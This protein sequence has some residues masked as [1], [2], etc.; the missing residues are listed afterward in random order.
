MD[1]PDPSIAA[2]VLAAGAGTRFGGP[3]GLARTAAGQPWVDRAVRTL[4]AAGCGH[5]LVAVGASAPEVTALLPPGSRAVAVPDWSDGISASVRAGLA[6]ATD[7]A[8]RALVMVTVDIPDLPVSAVRRVVS[9]GR[10]HAGG[11]PGL[12]H[13]LAQAVYR[14]R[15]GHPVLLGRVHWEP[16]AAS[17]SGDRGARPYLVA[18]GGVEVECGDLWSGED[19]DT[20]ARRPT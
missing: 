17:V 19:V 5:V 3:K 1:S 20:P 12:A 6:A 9:V 10:G 15:P 18:H 14:G 11:S 13:G 4:Q 8:A 2:L 16:I 7:T